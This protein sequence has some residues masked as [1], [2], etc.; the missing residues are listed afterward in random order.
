MKTVLISLFIANMLFV[1][2]FTV[3]STPFLTKVFKAV[4]KSDVNKIYKKYHENK[5]LNVIINFLLVCI[6][7]LFSIVLI[8]LSTFQ[9][10]LPTLIW[11]RSGIV[12]GLITIAATSVVGTILKMTVISKKITDK[13]FIEISFINDLIYY[14]SIIQ[15]I[16]IFTNIKGTKPDLLIK[17]IYYSN[18]YMNTT[19]MVFIISL[20]FS[21]IITNIYILY[22]RFTF[23]LT[24]NLQK[25]RRTSILLII[26]III[27][28]SF[29]GLFFINNLDLSYMTVKDKSI[30]DGAISIFTILLSSI[31]IPLGFNII[32]NKSGIN[33]E[34]IINHVTYKRKSYKNHRR[35]QR[36]RY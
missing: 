4:S 34:R 28:S 19:L 35:S 29:I 14:F 11:I 2:Y 12:P 22:K 1:L 26:S 3:K 13:K 5:F 33:E 31:L 23:L 15:A 20:Y 21:I 24:K 8:G 32:G 6:I 36:K 10:W 17:Q 9:I 25:Y 30:L 7:L 18:I 16:L 27:I